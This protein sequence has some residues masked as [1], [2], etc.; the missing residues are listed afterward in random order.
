MRKS[1]LRKHLKG[2]KN[3]IVYLIRFF[4]NIGEKILKFS[5]EIRLTNLK[6]NQQNS[7]IKEAKD[8]F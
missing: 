6:K 4:S 2:N 7:N 5:R 1:K 3:F 8:N